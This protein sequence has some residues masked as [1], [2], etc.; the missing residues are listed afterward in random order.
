MLLSLITP[1][2]Y[3]YRSRRMLCALTL[4]TLR[5]KYLGTTFGLVWVFLYPLFFLGIYGSVFAFILK[6][7]LAHQTTGEYI[8]MLFA[9]LVPFLGFSEMLSLSTVSVTSNRRLIKNTLFPL[10]LIPVQAVFV[11]AVGNLVGLLM[12]ICALLFNAGYSPLQLLI[13]PVLC[14]QLLFF[15]GVAWFFGSLAVGFRDL[16]QLIGIFILLLM[17]GTPIGYNKD[18]IPE[19]FLPLMYCNPLYHLTE[20]YRGFLLEGRIPWLE[21]YTFTGIALVFFYGGYYFFQ[22]LKGAILEYV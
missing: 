7:R 13:I 9:G 11:S 17:L 10:E 16:T 6:V 5:T 19:R 14:L 2:S 18:M 12:L 4:T 3:L 22:R 8:L 15:C 1:F 20:L 21:L